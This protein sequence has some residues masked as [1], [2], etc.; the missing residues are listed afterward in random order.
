MESFNRVFHFSTNSHILNILNHDDGNSISG[1]I[2][3][4]KCQLK[5]LL[6]QMVTSN[7]YLLI[8]DKVLVKNRRHNIL[9]CK[10]KKKMWKS[11]IGT[12]FSHNSFICLFSE[13]SLGFL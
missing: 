3:K 8:H 11:S 13:A 4:K 6:L 12:I 5:L 2:T 9:Q 10:G 7:W 1:L